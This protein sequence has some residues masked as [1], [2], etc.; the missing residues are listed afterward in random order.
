MPRFG[1]SRKV[2][3]NT[4]AAVVLLLISAIT[5]EAQSRVPRPAVNAPELRTARYFESIRKSPP[6][7]FAFLKRMPKGGDLHSHLSGAVYAESYI[8]W[9]AA[10]GLCVNQGALAIAQP[11][12]DPAAGKPPASAALSNPVLYRQI[13]DAMSMRNWQY[14]G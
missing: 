2:L 1:S 3:K 14:S 13:I 5:V 10:R 4:G 8:Q 7:M 11:P 9:A 6:E 12:C